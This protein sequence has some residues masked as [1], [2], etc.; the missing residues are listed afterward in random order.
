MLTILM[1]FYQAKIMQHLLEH[2]KTWLFLAF[3][4]SFLVA[5]FCLRS[6]TDLPRFALPFDK[7]G[8][9]T[10]HFG[11]VFFWFL[12]IKAHEKSTNFSIVTAVVISALFGVLMEI[13]QA[14]FTTTRFADVNDVFANLLGS[15]IG[16]VAVVGFRFFLKRL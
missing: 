12:G 1:H 4:W 8:H 7:I 11:M 3:F 6:A 2:K 10:F 14:V 16:V 9:L 5:F 15:G 13:C